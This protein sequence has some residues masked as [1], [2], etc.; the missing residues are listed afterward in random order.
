[1]SAATE[2]RDAGIAAA[3]YAADPRLILAVDAV[4]QRW[5]DSGRRF[6]AN[7]IRDEL[8]S[9]ARTIVGGRLRAAAM[10]KPQEIR[11]VGEVQSDLTSTHAKP[12]KVWQC[13]CAGCAPH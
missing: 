3:E 8:P 11:V 1:M 4:I 7:D 6:S 10:R 12:I 5:I 13:S 9:F 2:A